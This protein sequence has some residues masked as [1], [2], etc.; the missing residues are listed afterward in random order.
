MK[1]WKFTAVTIT[2][3]TVVALLAGREDIVRYVRMKRM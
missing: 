1:W 2:V 3:L